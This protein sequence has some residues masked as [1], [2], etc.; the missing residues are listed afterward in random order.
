MKDKIIFHPASVDEIKKKERANLTQPNKPGESILEK[1]IREH[2]E[3]LEEH[4]KNTGDRTHLL[5]PDGTRGANGFG[6]SRNLPHHLEYWYNHMPH[7]SASEVEFH[8]A[9]LRKNKIIEINKGIEHTFVFFV[10]P[11][12]IQRKGKR[13]ELDF[14][15]LH[16]GH[17]VALEVDGDSHLNKYHFDEEARLSNLRNNFLD[18]RR[19]RPNYIDPDWADKEVDLL[20]NYLEIRRGA[21]K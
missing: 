14:L 18:V 21:G 12:G 6:H 2:C 11:T 1:K 17:L 20:F 15:I 8:K 3:W 13:I 16:Q 5:N 19:I 10:L 7:R 4:I 9:L